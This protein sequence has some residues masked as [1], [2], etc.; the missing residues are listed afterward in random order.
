MALSRVALSNVPVP[1][2]A[3]K[4]LV[5]LAPLIPASVYVLPAQMVASGP[6]LAVV[7]GLIVKTI[8]ET[9]A[10]QGPAPSGSLVVRVRVTLPAV[11]SA[12][13]GVY[14]APSRAGLSNVPVPEVVQ[15]EDA[16]T[17]PIAPESV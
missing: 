15:V 13:E 9:A 8:E 3:Q 1:E 14:V 5:A 17:P 6:A 4:E 12:A 10:V 16:A 7:P 2:L 11:I